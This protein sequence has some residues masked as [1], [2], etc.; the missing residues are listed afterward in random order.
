M[1]LAGPEQGSTFCTCLSSFLQLAD[2][3]EEA[4]R[5]QRS[6]VAGLGPYRCKRELQEPAEP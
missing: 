6:C 2:W 5:V 4:L 3:A 1:A